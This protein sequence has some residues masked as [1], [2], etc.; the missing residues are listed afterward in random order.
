[1]KLKTII[2]WADAHGIDIERASITLDT[3]SYSGDRDEIKS[4]FTYETD[5]HCQISFQH[6]KETATNFDALVKAIGPFRQIGE[7]MG[8]TIR[9]EFVRLSGPIFLKVFW[10][11]CYSSK[12]KTKEVREYFMIPFKDD[13][14]RGVT[15]PIEAVESQEG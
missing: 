2:L 9:S 10:S 7:D 11:G 15:G 8:S 3:Y 1:M 14:T 4:K 13:T 5:S 6:S 12:V